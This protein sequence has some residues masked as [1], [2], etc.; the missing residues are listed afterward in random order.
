M[1]K[2]YIMILGDSRKSNLMV[3]FSRNV[4][5]MMALFDEMPTLLTP[6]DKQN[7]LYYLEGFMDY[8]EAQARYKGVIGMTKGEKVEL[9]ESVNP[10]WIEFKIGENIEL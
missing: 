6:P 9:I 3:V 2:F 1:R 10:D 4:Q 5:K 7:C 8:Q